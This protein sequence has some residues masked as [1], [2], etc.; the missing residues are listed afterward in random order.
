M[1]DTPTLIPLYSDEKALIEREV[2][3]GLEGF[4]RPESCSVVFYYELE[5]TVA[6]IK[7]NRYKRIALQFPDH[8]LSDSA[9]VATYIEKNATEGCR[10]YVLAD[11]SYGKCCV[12]EVAS[13]HISADA[14]IHYGPACL[15]ANS[16]LP[17]LYVFSQ[18]TW[19]VERCASELTKQFGRDQSVIVLFDVQHYYGIQHLRPLLS[20]EFPN[21]IFSEIPTKV[22]QRDTHS[23]VS[24]AQTT[25]KDPILTSENASNTDSGTPNAH[26]FS[27]RR[28]VLPE[29]VRLE[30]CQ[31]VYIGGEGATLTNIIMRY[32]TLTIWT[33][34]I[35]SEVLRKETVGANR[36]LMKRFFLIEKAKDADIIGI[37]VGTLAVSNYMDILSYLKKI[38][39]DAGKKYYTFV[40]GKLNIPKLANFAEIDMFVLVACPE[41]SLLD[42]KEFFRPI[43]TP[44]ELEIALVRGKEWSNQYTT[45][46]ADVLK[47]KDMKTL[48][49]DLMADG[50]E[51]TEG[52]DV[53]ISLIASRV[54]VNHKTAITIQSEEHTADD[55][56]SAQLAG[57][58]TVAKR[59]AW[60]IAQ[61]SGPSASTVFLQRTFQGLQQRLGED[62][63]HVATEGQAGIAAGYD[64]EAQS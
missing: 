9:A 4:H 58:N 37:V 27:G 62:V 53:R 41:N 55:S 51:Q 61:L 8:L 29:G 43:V 35:A 12:D 56:K 15:S 57:S 39:R 24:S 60:D 59:E 28:F 49:S 64:N 13:E 23:Y 45:D 47:S 63:P 1:S 46:F 11:T 19:N 22:K 14:L 5:Q 18:Q 44:F 30:D 17:V 54:K 33:Y 42:S 48:E 7:Q 6:W 38:I 32:N 25:S 16:R 40:M 10:A 3:T 31:I 50:S 26:V 21:F 20:A 52:E 2:D 34:S 36:A